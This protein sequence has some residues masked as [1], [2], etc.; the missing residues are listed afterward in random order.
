MAR[1]TKEWLEKY[2]TEKAQQFRRKFVVARCQARYWCQPWTLTYEQYVD[3]FDQAGVM[4]RQIGT[5]PNSYNLLRVD[6]SKGWSQHNTRVHKRKK[7]MMRT[8]S[9]TK[10]TRRRDLD[11]K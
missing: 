11:G 2:P 6:T 5:K 4:P 8:K 1:R 10:R 3:L 9:T 7:M